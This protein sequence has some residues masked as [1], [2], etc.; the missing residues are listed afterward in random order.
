MHPYG[1]MFMVLR[2]ITAVYGVMLS[3]KFVASMVRVYLLES[4]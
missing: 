4:R 1:Q 2:I 3:L